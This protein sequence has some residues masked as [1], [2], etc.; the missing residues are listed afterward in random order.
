MTNTLADK[1]VLVLAH[2]DLS[3]SSAQS[4]QVS[5]SRLELLHICLSSFVDKQFYFSLLVSRSFKRFVVYALLV[6]VNLILLKFS[7]ASYFYFI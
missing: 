7:A 4:K 5:C 2:Y 1:G 6:T 3:D